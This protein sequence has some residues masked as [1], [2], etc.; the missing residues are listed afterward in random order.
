MLSYQAFKP[1]DGLVSHEA[2][3]GRDVAAKVDLPNW[4]L[5]S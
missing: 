2:L 4:G 1:F 5:P 3:S